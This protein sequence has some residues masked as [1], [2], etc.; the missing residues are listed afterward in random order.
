MFHRLCRWW[1]LRRRQLQSEESAVIQRDIVDTMNHEYAELVEDV[2][3]P[4]SAGLG[5]APV[6]YTEE[7]HTRIKSLRRSIGKELEQRL[8][9]GID[10]DA[11]AEQ[12]EKRRSWRFQSI[13]SE[14]RLQLFHGYIDDAVKVEPTLL[15]D[16][17]VVRLLSLDI[18]G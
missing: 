12:E 3:G 7:T 9:T 17:S 16:P 10:L 5:A 11:Y 14:Y 2:F 6:Y 4:T 8:S 13:D 1:S 15:R 18:I